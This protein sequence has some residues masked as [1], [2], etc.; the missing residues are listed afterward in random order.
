MMAPRE[1][2]RE[3]EWEWGMAVAV[4]AVEAWSAIWRVKE[5]QMCGK[6]GD[7]ERYYVLLQYMYPQEPGHQEAR[8]WINI[9]IY[10]I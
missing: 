2:E 5:Q 6:G 4:E 3:W 1:W 10:S 8:D 9:L 7:N